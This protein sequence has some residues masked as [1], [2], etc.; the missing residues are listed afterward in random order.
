MDDQENV[1]EQKPSLIAEA[2]ESNTALEEG[3]FAP[4][5]DYFTMER[6][7]LDEQKDLRFIYQWARKQ[8]AEE[9]GEILAKIKKL[10]IKLGAPPTGENRM[11]RL[12]NYLKIDAQLDSLLLEQSVYTK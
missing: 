8:G 1:Q 12:I 9:R 4:L 5:V 11:K 2:P 3:E 10:E 7:N 6:P